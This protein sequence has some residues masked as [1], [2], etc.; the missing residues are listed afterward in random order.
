MKEEWRDIAGY[1]KYYQVSDL[2]RVR[3]LDRVVPHS[4]GGPK[5]RKGRVL[6]SSSSSGPYQTV[7]LS[8]EAKHKQCTVHR[9]VAIAFLGPCP[10][11]HQV[12]HGPNGK[13]D[14]RLSNLAYGTQSQNSLDKYRDGTCGN[15]PVRRSDGKEYLSIAIAA[16]K[17]GVCEG[18][19]S[20]VCRKYIKPNG[21]PV[22]TA[23]GFFWEF[24]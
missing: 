7:T 20:A 10:S 2:G 9:L 23:G 6:R 11:G 19:I 21:Y 3:S 15:K 5:R 24:I 17:T 12:R 18:G 14:N 8:V 16:R 4:N 1:E 13:L 22:L